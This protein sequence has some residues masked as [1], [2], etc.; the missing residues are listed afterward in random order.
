M[1]LNNDIRYFIRNKVEAKIVPV[2]MEQDY[3]D[4][5]NL[6]KQFNQYLLAE[7]NALIDKRVAEFLDTHPEL[8]GAEISNPLTSYH[9]LY[10]QMHTSRISKEIEELRKLRQD[11]IDECVQRVCID[12]VSCKDTEELLELIAKITGT[13]K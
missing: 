4:V 8:D 6:V 11:F 5:C 13:E 1:R 7:C 9:R 3:E 10:L 2:S 12:A